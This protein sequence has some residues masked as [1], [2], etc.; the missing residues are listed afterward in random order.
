MHAMALLITSSSAPPGQGAEIK[1]HAQRILQVSH[2]SIA[3]LS[4]LQRTVQLLR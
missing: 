3:V 2:T 4:V 1:A